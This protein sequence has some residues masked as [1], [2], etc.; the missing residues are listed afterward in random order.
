M[1]EQ[2]PQRDKGIVAAAHINSQAGVIVPMPVCLTPGA[3]SGY[4]WREKMLRSEIKGCE[5]TQTEVIVRVRDGSNQVIG[6]KMG[7]GGLRS[8]KRLFGCFFLVY[9]NSSYVERSIK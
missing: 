3:G 6:V 1:R 8:Y 5:C 7:A 4:Q 9:L 2:V